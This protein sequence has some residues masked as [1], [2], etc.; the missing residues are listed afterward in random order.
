MKLKMKK[1]SVYV[2]GDGKKDLID[3]LFEVIRLLDEDFTE[4]S[5]LNETSDYAFK[6]REIKCSAIPD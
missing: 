2:N 4:G 5:N 1:L 6:V 3:S